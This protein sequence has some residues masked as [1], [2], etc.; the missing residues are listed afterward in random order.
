G[1]RPEALTR[2]PMIQKETRVEVVVEIDEKTVRA[3]ANLVE[4]ALPFRTLV[5]SAGALSPSRLQVYALG[6]QCEH[7]REHGESFVASRACAFERDRRRRRVLLHAGV[8]LAV[9]VQVD[10][11]G[12]LRHIRVV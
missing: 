3:F 1:E 5:L 11:E 7:I 12:V 8:A 4:R 9:G 6:G 10:R 2:R